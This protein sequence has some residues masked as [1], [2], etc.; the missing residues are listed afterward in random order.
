MLGQLLALS[1]SLF[2]LYSRSE[3]HTLFSIPA[4]NTAYC[5]SR[6]LCLQW[7]PFL[8]ACKM[9]VHHRCH[10]NVPNN[11]GLNTKDMATVLKEI[12]FT[13]SPG[14]KKVR[15]YAS[16]CRTETA[17]ALAAYLSQHGFICLFVLSSMKTNAVTGTQVSIVLG[18]NLLFMS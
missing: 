13:A 3:N 1:L 14:R 4:T 6:V 2:L 8:T 7:R 5:H 16:R 11:C 15:L 10:K 9:N 12:G 17:A 18:P